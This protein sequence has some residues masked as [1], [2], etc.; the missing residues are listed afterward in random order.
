MQT[1]S[2]AQDVGNASAMAPAEAA[3]A[4]GVQAQQP[5][6]QHEEEQTGQ[7]AKQ[8]VPRQ[9][10]T[11]MPTGELEWHDAA[12]EAQC[13]AEQ[14]DAS[15]RMSAE[16]ARGD[17]PQDAASQPSGTAAAE[18]SSGADGVALPGV[19][20]MISAA[21]AER[22]EQAAYLRGRN[23]AIRAAW[24]PTPGVATAEAEELPATLLRGRR[25]VWEA[26]G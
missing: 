7:Q 12:L 5:A 19:V 24:L 11:A 22:R 16:A 26:F 15:T 18:L 2:N 10:V 17:V 8:Q 13:R 3:V 25:S 9:V 1:L 14:A 4:P 21:E 20:R 23:E 6:E